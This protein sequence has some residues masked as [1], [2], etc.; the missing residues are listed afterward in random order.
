[1]CNFNNF[2]FAKLLL[3][4]LNVRTQKTNSEGI[5]SEWR[6][7]I[8]KLRTKVTKQSVDAIIMMEIYKL[9]VQ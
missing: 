7:L 3:L 1:M 2:D 6:E 4:K 8:A 9:V 5:R